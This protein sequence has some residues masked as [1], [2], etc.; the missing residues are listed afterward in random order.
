M[1]YKEQPLEVR[2][3]TLAALR[4]PNGHTCDGKVC[5]KEHT[6][7]EVSALVGASE[8]V[9]H[10]NWRTAKGKLAVS[11][12]QRSSTLHARL[13][14]GALCWRSAQPGYQATAW[15]SSG[16][17]GP[18]NAKLNDLEPIYQAWLT[19]TEC[20]VRQECFEYVRPEEEFSGVCS[21]RVWIAGKDRTDTFL[22]AY[23][24]L[25]E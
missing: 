23:A 2:V 5:P 3:Y 16:R 21:A 9:V 6:W 22:D 11:R 12:T 10:R 14:A 13:E 17:E 7:K 15:H 24:D 18:S 25:V 20:P 8:S 19:C 4:T 1:S